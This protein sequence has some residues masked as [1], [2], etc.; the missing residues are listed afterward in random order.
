MCGIVG[1]S[2]RTGRYRATL[3]QLFV[4]MLNALATRG[5]DS[6]GVAIYSGVTAASYSG[7]TAASWKY[8]L[9]APG[10]TGGGTTSRRI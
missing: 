1:L 7:G 6:A 5:P 4:P 2:C 3:G 9:R 10:R 8:S